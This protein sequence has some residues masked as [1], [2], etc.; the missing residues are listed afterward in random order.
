MSPEQT[1][2]ITLNAKSPG[3]G[4]QLESRT[5]SF[6]CDKG[7]SEIKNSYEKVLYDAIVGDQ[8]LFTTTEEVLAAW[9]YI[10]PILD[11]WQDL[12]LHSYNKGSAGPDESII[13]KDS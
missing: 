4:F 1:M 7:Q 6:T 9:K 11:V 8:T 10:S 5:L 2:S 3:L 12:P 13:P